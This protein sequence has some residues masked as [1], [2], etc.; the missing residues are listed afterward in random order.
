MYQI[1]TMNWDIDWPSKKHEKY[2]ERKEKAWGLLKLAV[3]PSI[4]EEAT[5]HGTPKDFYDWIISYYQP[6]D[7]VYQQ[8]LFA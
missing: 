3:V 6:K 8:L 1:R 5:S 4:R 7:A 2:I